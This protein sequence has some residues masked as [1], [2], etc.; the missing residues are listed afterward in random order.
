MLKEHLKK[1][2][3]KIRTIK[4]K[5]H[6][7]I[8]WWFWIAAII[9]FASIFWFQ[10]INTHAAEPIWCERIDTVKYLKIWQTWQAILGCDTQISTTNIKENIRATNNT[11]TELIVTEIPDTYYK[12]NIEFTFENNWFT[13]LY[14]QENEYLNTNNWTWEII[15]VYDTYYRHYCEWW[16]PETPIYIGEEWKIE[17][18]CINGIKQNI[19]GDILSNIYAGSDIITYTGSLRDSGTVDVNT[20]INSFEFTY[21]WNTSWITSFTLSG[22]EIINGASNAQIKETK[23][24]EIVVKEIKEE[25]SDKLCTIKADPDE[26]MIWE[27]WKIIVTCEGIKNNNETEEIEPTIL[28]SSQLEYSWIILDV[29]QYGTW[30]FHQ[31][32]SKYT[33]TF[34]YTWRLWWRS[35][36]GRLWRCV[37]FI[38]EKQM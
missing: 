19:E 13:Q 32:L 8:L 6:H 30:E 28:S 31:E 16:E 10:N 1:H 33:Y 5:R 24:N 7:Y 27:T 9:A 11:I 26:R 12:Y 38:T 37:C 21:T 20:Y 29:G 18:N 17:L 15:R 35:E 3:N 14:I 25:Y 36:C 4:L 22:T 34:I 23:S 2:F